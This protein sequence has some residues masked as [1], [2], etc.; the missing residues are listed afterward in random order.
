MIVSF[1]NEPF[2]T[3]VREG[4]AGA[5]IGEILE[6][7]KPEAAYFTELNGQRTGVLVVDL[8]S[9]SGI[10]ALAEPWFLRLNATC[11][12]HPAMTIEDLQQGNL[13]EIGK[14]WG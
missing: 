7:T 5:T 6:A 9:A 14:K 12:L 8:P 2:N 1:P 3:L 10:P 4:D 13:D 11:K